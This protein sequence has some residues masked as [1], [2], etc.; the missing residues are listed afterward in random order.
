MKQKIQKCLSLTY[1]SNITLSLRFLLQRN[2]LITFLI[3]LKYFILNCPSFQ[4]YNKNVI[5]FPSNS[6]LLKSCFS[7]L[8]IFSC[9]LIYTLNFLLNSTIASFA[10]FKFFSFPQVLCFT[11]KPIRLT[12]RICRILQTFITSRRIQR[13][14]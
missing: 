1:N 11:I 10:F 8:F 13:T 2:T 14:E 7:T 6:H 9:L 4:L 3:F 5:Y 12:N